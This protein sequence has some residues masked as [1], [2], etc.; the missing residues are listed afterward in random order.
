[1]TASLQSHLEQMA[2]YHH[3]ATAR[4]LSSVDLVPDEDYRRD[5]GLFFASIHGTVNHLLLTD[6]MIW[7]PRFS[8][9]EVASRSLDAEVEGDRALLASRLLEATAVWSG[10]VGAL[11]EATLAGE[12]AYRMTTGQQRRLPM[13]AALNHVFNHATHH[14]GQVT[15]ALSQMG[16]DYEPLDLPFMIFEEK[17]AS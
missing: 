1:M 3:W 10:F 7:F 15:A 16:H 17:S 13:A 5:C 11:D 12:L 2:R 8:G 4:L 9:G 14:R 6:K